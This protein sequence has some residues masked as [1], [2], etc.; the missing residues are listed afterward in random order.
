MTNVHVVPEGMKRIP[1]SWDKIKI[2]D[3][4]LQKGE[5][6]GG[7]IRSI[8]ELVTLLRNYGVPIHEDGRLDIIVSKE[9]DF[10]VPDTVKLPWLSDYVIA[11]DEAETRRFVPRFKSKKRRLKIGYSEV[12]IGVHKKI[13]LH[14]DFQRTLESMGASEAAIGYA[15]PDGFKEFRDAVADFWWE[16]FNERIY[17]HNVIGWPGSSRGISESAGALARDATEIILTPGYANYKPLLHKQNTGVVAVPTNWQDHS[18]ALPSSDDLENRIDKHVRA[19]LLNYPGNPSGATLNEQD[20]LMFI[21]LAIK[22]GIWLKLDLPYAALYGSEHVSPLKFGSLV[23]L[24]TLLIYSMSK[25]YAAGP[26]AA[27]TIT[28]RP[29]LN[30]GLGKL[31]QCELT[32]LSTLTQQAMIDP[33]RN[34]P[35]DYLADT[36]AEHMRRVDTVLEGLK[37]IPGFVNCHRPRGSYYELPEFKDINGELLV[38]LLASDGYSYL[39]DENGGTPIERTAIILPATGFFLDD[40]Y[41][42]ANYEAIMRR[43]RYASVEPVE[44]AHITTKIVR[45]SIVKLRGITDG[46]PLIPEHV[47]KF[48]AHIRA[49]PRVNPQI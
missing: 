40:D 22:H 43:F 41:V 14:A 45:D 13:K 19:F 2:P 11:F 5:D 9:M 47:E 7:G 21:R 12:H 29:D 44:E 26:R 36:S 42:V 17:G 6:E 28:F 35:A 32:N 24:I 37:K 27:A 15:P 49:L 20:V 34:N 48:R 38:E 4:L 30:H 46:T 31:I 18:Y 8:P 39:V 3:T 25:D 16:V 33:L 23:Y 1:V 10:D